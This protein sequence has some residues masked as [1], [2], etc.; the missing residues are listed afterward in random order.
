MQPSMLGRDRI[1][2]FF[3]FLRTLAD[4]E[5]LN[6]IRTEVVLICTRS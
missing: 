4:P 3:G 1:H 5:V 6:T 2:F